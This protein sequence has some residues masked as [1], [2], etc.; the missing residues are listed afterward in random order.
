MADKLIFG[1]AFVV[2][3]MY[4]GTLLGSSMGEA[5]YEPVNDP[6]YSLSSGAVNQSVALAAAMSLGSSYFGGCNLNLPAH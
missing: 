5:I 4:C 1:V 2:I 6:G 3:A